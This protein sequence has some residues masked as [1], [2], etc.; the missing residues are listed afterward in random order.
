MRTLKCLAS[1]AASSYL[2]KEGVTNGF[3]NME[4]EMIRT[5]AFGAL[6]SIALTVPAMAATTSSSSAK[7]AG[8]NRI[9]NSAAM[10]Q[11]IRTQ[12][13]SNGFTQVSTM[14]RG[15]LGRWQGTA[16]KDGKFVGVS[17]LFPP[18]PQSQSLTD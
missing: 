2:N 4:F 12:L 17:V 16:M 15:P 5:F 8:V 18:A 11:Q 1:D 6:A 10:G 3:Q 9:L 13:M 7:E 14:A